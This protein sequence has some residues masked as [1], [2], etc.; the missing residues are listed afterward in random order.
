[1]LQDMGSS[2]DQLGAGIQDIQL[3]VRQGNRRHE[4]RLD[5]L[6]ELIR[7]YFHQD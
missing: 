4:E 2:Y 5:S 6:E 7:G 3:E 1:M